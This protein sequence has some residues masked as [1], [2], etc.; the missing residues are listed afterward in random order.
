MLKEEPLVTSVAKVRFADAKQLQKT[1]EGTLAKDQSGKAIGNIQVDELTNSLIIQ[2]I[3][4]DI[5]KVTRLLARLDSP[6]AQIKLKAHIV[7][8]TKEVARDLGIMDIAVSKIPQDGRFTFT[9]QNREFNVRVSSLPTVHGENLV[10]RLLERNASGLSLGE[11]GLAPA[12]RLKVE[13]AVV[14]PY[15]LIVAAGPTGSGKSTTLYAL[16]R[17]INRPDINIV[18]LEDPVEYRIPTVRQAQL[19]RKA[20]MTTKA[21]QAALNSAVAEGIAHFNMAYASYLIE[22][23]STPTYT[24]LTTTTSTTGD[25]AVYLAETYDSGDYRITYTS[26]TKTGS[27][28]LTVKAY[29]KTD[30]A[31]A[32]PTGEGATADATKFA[33]KTINVTWGSS[34]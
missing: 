27:G 29:L 22:Q 19:N 23:Q 15:G 17:H 25:K 16:L 20:G 2:S 31:A 30:E 6:R 3:S 1:L 33:S 4:A 34:S 24:Q 7:E 9:T 32:A 8:T 14:K 5:P 18:T 21:K 11:L 26:T 13:S 12:D 10:L 28:D